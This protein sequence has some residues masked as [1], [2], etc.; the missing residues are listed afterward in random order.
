M[1]QWVSGAS[2]CDNRELTSRRSKRQIGG[3]MC[4]TGGRDIFH[5]EYIQHR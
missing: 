4:N 2:P 1:I 3:Q 5:T